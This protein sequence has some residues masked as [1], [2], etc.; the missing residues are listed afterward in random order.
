MDSRTMASIN[1]HAVL[2]ACVPLIENDPVAREIVKD[3]NISVRFDIPGIEPR[4]LIFDHGTARSEAPG[5][6]KPDLRLGFGC[7][8]HFNAMVAGK[9]IPVP[10][11]GVHRMGFLLG[12]FTKLTDRL[13]Y[14]LQTPEGAALTAEE[15]DLK[16]FLTANVAFAALCEVANIDPVGQKL[17]HGMRDGALIVEV[18][19]EGIKLACQVKDHKLT[20]SPDGSHTD[21][22]AWMTFDS[23]ET[24]RA[25]LDGAVDTYALIGQDKL[26]MS[27]VILNIDAA[28]K[29]LGRVSRYLA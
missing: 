21:P 11:W 28:N 15:E 9:G 25:V 8:A 13:S 20:F 1:L 27:G 3:S 4:T 26:V 17:A 24:F 12:P 5:P 19:S 29:M 18:P 2:R 10:L 22:N 14:I 7:P 6:S 16:T 23:K